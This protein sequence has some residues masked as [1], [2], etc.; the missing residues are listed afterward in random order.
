MST[1]KGG[2]GTHHVAAVADVEPHR[3]AWVRRPPGGHQIGQQIFA[4][5]E[6]RRHAQRRRKSLGER[7]LEPGRVV[8]QLHRTGQER[9]AVLVQHQAA[10]DA[11]E[12]GDAEGRFELGE[13]RAR[14]RLRPGDPTGRGA[15]RAGPRRGHEDL[16]AGQRQAQTLIGYIG[17]DERD[18]PLFGSSKRRYDAAMWKLFSREPLHDPIAPPVPGATNEIKTTTCYMCACRCGI[19]V[20]LRDG[21]V[22]YIDGNPANTR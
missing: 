3:L 7:G 10:A 20:H 8:E 9:A 5:G 6:A 15:R 12:Q 14:R 22:R 11:V 13:R 19:R 2:D 18:Y 17:H 16:E 21:E 4:D 1:S